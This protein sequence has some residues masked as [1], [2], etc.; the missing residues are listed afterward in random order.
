[1]HCKMGGMQNIPSKLHTLSVWGWLP[2]VSFIDQ[3][4]KNTNFILIKNLEMPLSSVTT[5]F[6]VCRIRFIVLTFMLFQ[7]TFINSDMAFCSWMRVAMVFNV[8]PISSFSITSLFFYI[9]SL[10]QVK[11][12]LHRMKDWK[13]II[14]IFH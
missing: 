13:P 10:F 2:W 14:D 8:I 9:V 7:I 1:M 6:R 4:I 11:L 3:S 12:W 5:L